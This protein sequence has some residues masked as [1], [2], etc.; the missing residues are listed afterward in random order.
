MEILPMHK[1]DLGAGYFRYEVLRNGQVI[2]Q[3]VSR[4]SFISAFV[5]KA[6]GYVDQQTDYKILKMFGRKDLFV[7]AMSKTPAIQ[8]YAVA[9]LT[10]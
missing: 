6:P 9:E 3:R 4:K 7:K 10:Q 1:I 5:V 2:A 8:L